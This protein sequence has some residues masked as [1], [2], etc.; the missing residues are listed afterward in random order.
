[1]KKNLLILLSFYF[2]VLQSFVI[3]LLRKDYRFFT[4]GIV[5]LIIII[6]I[7]LIYNYFEK[8]KKEKKKDNTETSFKKEKENLLIENTHHKKSK[9]KAPLFLLSLIIILIIFLALNGELTSNKIIIS[10]GIGFIVY[11]VLFYSLSR[12]K[13]GTFLGLRSSKLILIIFLFGLVVNGFDSGISETRNQ[14]I[15]GT[16]QNI[17]SNKNIEKTEKETYQELQDIDEGTGEIISQDYG[18]N[19]TGENI[20]ISDNIQDSDIEN[21][22]TDIN[23][24]FLNDGDITIL[25]AIKY[26]LDINNIPLDMNQN[27]KFKYISY[28]NE[29]YPYFKTAYMK[30]M[31]G[32]NTNPDKEI[33]CQTYIVMKGIVEGRNV[34]S[35]GD[36]LTNYL[37][38]ASQLGKL[39]GCER[40]KYVSL[41][42]L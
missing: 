15:I 27:V 3:G 13:K 10:S 25:D 12:H 29:N 11:I 2:F 41:E 20:K 22:A 34:S 30:K 38:K 14:T 42:N 18:E 26:L 7:V 32:S 39:N 9:K 5:N 1:M 31:I 40:N 8:D 24:N 17:F 36:P 19:I 35:G 28:Q 4:L 33:I 23:Q 16:I 37:N 6:A 21:T